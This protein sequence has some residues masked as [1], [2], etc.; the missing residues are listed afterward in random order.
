M[1][2]YDSNNLNRP[3]NTDDQ[4]KPLAQWRITLGASKVPLSRAGEKEALCGVSRHRFQALLL[5]FL[6]SLRTS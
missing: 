2:D 3:Q 5:P 6:F 4:R 1:H